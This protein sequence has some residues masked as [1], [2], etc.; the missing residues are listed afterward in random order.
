MG[1]MKARDTING[2]E[3]R[4]YAKINGLNEE[5]YYAKKVEAKIEKNKKALKTLG[6]RGEQSKTI[7]FKGTGSMT[8]YYVS[9]LFRQMIMDYITTGKDVYFDMQVINDDPDSS[10]GKQTTVLKN[11]NIDGSTVALFDIDSE[12]LS[13]EVSFTFDGVEFLDKFGKPVLG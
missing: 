2:G 11:V 7:G 9:P 8:L 5:M 12:E 10:V 1:F 13:E 4:A 3:A 6:K